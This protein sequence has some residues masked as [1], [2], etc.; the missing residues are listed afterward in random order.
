M[1]LGI[2]FAIMSLVCFFGIFWGIQFIIDN[3]TIDD[4]LLTPLAGIWAMLTS[5]ATVASL[6]VSLFYFTN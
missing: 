4:W 5:F 2:L 1:L 3:F 6:R